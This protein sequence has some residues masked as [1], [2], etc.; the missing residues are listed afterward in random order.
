MPDYIALKDFKYREAERAEVKHV[1]KGQIIQL[2]DSLANPNIEDKMV[3][4]EYV[5]K[6]KKDEK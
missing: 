3:R 6:A 4:F 2:K 1:K 5:R